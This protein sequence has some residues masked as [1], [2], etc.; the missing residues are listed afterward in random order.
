M[1]CF[2]PQSCAGKSTKVCA[3]RS[4]RLK[5]AEVS[6]SEVPPGTTAGGVGLGE[7]CRPVGPPPS[8]Q[9]RCP[10]DG[11]AGTGASRGHVHRACWWAPTGLPRAL[12]THGCRLQRTNQL[13][14]AA[15]AARLAEHS[16]QV[17]GQSLLSSQV[18]DAPEGRALRRARAAPSARSLRPCGPGH[19]DHCP[20]PHTCVRGCLLW[21]PSQLEPEPRPGSA[22]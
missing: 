17:W 10:V 5:G 20:H 18:T 2:H 7:Q 12:Q 16:L 21:P 8:A 3:P 4:T 19:R 13:R 11:P 6:T 22:L 14:G 9:G 1:G 15:G